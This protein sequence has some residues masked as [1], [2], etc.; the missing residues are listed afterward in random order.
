M[1]TF[2]PYTPG[3]ADDAG[4]G[5]YPVLEPGIYR[6]TL[7]AVEAKDQTLVVSWDAF[8]PSQQRSVFLKDWLNMSKSVC[9]HRLKQLA[10]ASNRLAEF[11]AGTFD[12]GNLI[13]QT[14][15]IKITK[16]KS[17]DGDGWKNWI[18]DII[19][20]EAPANAPAAP[21]VATAVPPPQQTHTPVANEDIP[22]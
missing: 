20:P 15:N 17:R 4:G 8:D 22:F 11:E 1:S 13:N 14:F 3:I 18:D 12:A 6:G 2:I 16:K 10:R 7:T 21:P 9:V 5:E 19:P